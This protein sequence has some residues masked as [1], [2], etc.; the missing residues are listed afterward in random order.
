MAFP[1][2]WCRFQQQFNISLITQAE[3][4][5]LLKKKKKNKASADKKVDVLS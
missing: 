5:A 4:Q 2:H 1:P 3:F